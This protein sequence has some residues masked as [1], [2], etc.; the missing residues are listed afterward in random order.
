MKLKLKKLRPSYIKIVA[1][2]LSL[3]SKCFQSVQVKLWNLL[4]VISVP[5]DIYTLTFPF[6]LR[7][8]SVILFYVTCRLK[9]IG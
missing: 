3:A 6:N 9:R 1:S 2:T 8:E 4:I 7:C 5:Y